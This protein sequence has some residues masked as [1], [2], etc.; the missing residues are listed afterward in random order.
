MIEATLDHMELGNLMFGHSRGTFLVEPRDVY[1][2]IFLEF[3]YS[4]GCSFEG[5]SD[6]GDDVI[7][8]ETFAIRP[9]Y[10][11]DDE[12]IAELPNFVYKPM[13]FELRWYKYPMRDAYCN[14][15]LSPDEFRDILESCRASLAQK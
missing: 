7:E 15:D 8:N 2:D 1:Q 14:N 3:L 5:F 11:G 13:D 4:I 12:D 10:W 9:Y 6:N